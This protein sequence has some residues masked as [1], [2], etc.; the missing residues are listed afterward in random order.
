MRNLHPQ[1]ATDRQILIADCIGNIFPAYIKWDLIFN[2]LIL[3]NVT[4]TKV[5]AF[6]YFEQ[7]N[8]L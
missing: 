6:P 2:L 8:P 4:V 7:S 5:A 1:R 3:L